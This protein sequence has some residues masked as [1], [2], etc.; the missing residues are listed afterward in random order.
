MES[1][2]KKQKEAIEECIELIRSIGK[3]MGRAGVI[4]A[5]ED[6]II[7]GLCETIGYGAVMDS[8][9]R[10]WALRDSYGETGAFTV[11]PCRATVKN[12][13]K[14]LKEAGL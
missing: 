14:R 10:Q 13:I 6:K 5:S 11:G 4:H 8:A 1:L 2:N 3:E 9:A 12:V 7:K